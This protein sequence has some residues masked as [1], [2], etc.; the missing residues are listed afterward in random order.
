MGN[1]VERRSYR[2]VGR[3]LLD[4]ALQDAIPVSGRDMADVI[5]FVCEEHCGDQA[6]ELSEALLDSATDG[7]L[8]RD[9]AGSPLVTCHVTDFD[10]EVEELMIE[11][12]MPGH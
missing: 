9:A 12:G 7:F 6:I 4:D 5:G 8:H 11:F 3:K 1:V 2:L 10:N